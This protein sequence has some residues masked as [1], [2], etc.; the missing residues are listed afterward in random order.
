MRKMG[1]CEKWIKWISMCLTSIQYSVLV[2]GESVGSIVPGRGLRQG[3]PLSP[4]LF[5]LC[6][7][8]LTYLIKKY[9]GRGDIHGVRVCRGAPSLSHLLFADDCFLFFRADVRK[10]QCMKQILNN[11]EKASDQAINYAKSEV[12][13][14]RNTSNDIKIQISDTLGVSEVMGTW[15][16]LG[17]PSMIGRNKKAL[18]GYLKDR[19]WKKIQG[20]SGKHLSKA[21]REV[22]VKSVAQVIPTYC[23]STVL[24]PESLGDELEKMINSFWW[25]SNKS[26][27][28]GINWLRWEKLAMRKE[29]GGMGFRHF[30]GFNLAMLGKQG[31]HLLT[32]HDTILSRIFKA[33]YYP[34]TGFLE[35]NLGHNPS[36][37]WRS[38]HA[39]QVVVRRGLKWRLGNGNNINVWKQPWLRDDHQ[40]HVTTEM[41]TGREDMRVAGLVNNNTGMWNH[42]LVQQIFNERDVA[43]ISKIP[44]NLLTQDD[45]QIWRYSKKGIYTVRSAYYQLME[46]IID[47]NHLKE[48]GNWRQLWKIQVPNKVKIFMWRLLRGCLPVR[49]RLVRKG[50]PCDN[51]CPNCGSYEE[52]E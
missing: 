8:G 30:Y 49:S 43:A 5:I 10:A 11:Y 18:V 25:G 14:S 28:R 35:A 21:G 20:W 17:M 36:Y 1:F 37:V 15:C 3:D 19:M 39:S 6:T 45:E 33:K 40:T 2:N 26:S 24:L 51:K 48:Q 32:N 4:Y 23:M 9:E 34:K 38:I 41:I 31:W 52:N 46:N 16:Y 22:L 29:Y 47:N 7:E 13:F 27:G 12:Y 42:D 50:V 44:L